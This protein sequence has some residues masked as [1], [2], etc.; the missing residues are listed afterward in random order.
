MAE[1]N[2]VQYTE[3]DVQSFQNAQEMVLEQESDDLEPSQVPITLSSQMKEPAVDPEVVAAEKILSPVGSGSGSIHDLFRRSSDVDSVSQIENETNKQG[4]SVASFNA[5]DKQM[6]VHKMTTRA[7]S[8]YSSQSRDSVSQ[9]SKVLSIGGSLRSRSI[10]TASSVMSRVSTY[11]DSQI[12]DIYKARKLNQQKKIE[13]EKI[14]LQ[15]SISQEEAE[16]NERMRQEEEELRRKRQ[17]EK[18]SFQKRKERELNELKRRD[19]R[20]Q[21]ELD[22]DFTEAMAERGL[23]FDLPAI[24]DTNGSELLLGTCTNVSNSNEIQNVSPPEIRSNS[25]AATI[26]NIVQSTVPSQTMFTSAAR[27]PSYSLG[28]V[29][30]SVPA[31]GGDQGMSVYSSSPGFEIC[32]HTTSVLGANECMV[33]ASTASHNANNHNASNSIILPKQIDSAVNPVNMLANQIQPIRMSS[34]AACPTCTA[35]SSYFATST[36]GNNAPTSNCMTYSCTDFASNFSSNTG[37]IPLYNMSQAANGDINRLTMPIINEE[38]T[39]INIPQP[40]QVP[41]QLSPQVIYVPQQANLPP[42]EP[43]VFSGDPGEYHDFIDIFDTVIAAKVQNAKQRFVYLLQYTRGTAR[44]L[45]KGCQHKGS[46]CYDEALKLLA[47]TYGHKL[48]IEQACLNSIIEGPQL[49]TNDLEALTMFAA[50]LI[51]C[52]NTLKGIKNKGLSLMIIDKISWRMPSVWRPGWRTLVDD[53]LHV[54]EKD[55]TLAHLVSYVRKKTRELSN[56]S[57]PETNNVQKPREIANKPMKQHKSYFTTTVSAADKPIPKCFKC[58]GTHFLNQCQ[59]FRNMKHADRERFVRDLKLCFSCLQKGHWSRQCRRENPCRVPNCKRKHTTLLHPP[60]NVNADDQSEHHKPA[61]DASVSK[62]TNENREENKFSAFVNS[63]SEARVLLNVIPVKVRVKGQNDVVLTNAFFD[64]GST[65]SFMS[66]ALMQRLNATGQETNL[67]IRTISNVTEQK[68]SS[69]IND[70]ELSH[71]DESDFIA[72]GQLF[73]NKCIDID[74]SNIP[75][76]KDVDQFHEFKDVVIPRLNQKVGLL[77]GKDNFALHKPLEIV[78]GPDE[79]FAVRCPAGW[80]ISCPPKTKKVERSNSNF[81]VKSS[82]H[83]LCKMCT[84]VVDSIQNEKSEFS[85]NQE[86]F[87]ERVNKSIHLTTDGHYEIDL[88]FKNPNVILPKN[89]SHAEQRL[90]YLRRRFLKEPDFYNEYKSFV[91]DM[92]DNGYAEKVNNSGEC[93]GKTWYL[94]HHGV[95]HPEKKSLRVVFDCSAKFSGLCLND[96]LLQGPD[97]ANNLVGVLARFRKQSVAIQGDIRAMFHQVKVSEPHRDF[98]RFLWW[99]NGDV[100]QPVACFRMTSFLFG[101]ICSPSCANFALKRTAEDNKEDFSESTVT[102]VYDAFYVDDFLD[103]KPNAEE[104]ID[105]VKNVRNLVSKGGFEITKW[106]SNDRAV[107]LSIPEEHRAKDVKGLDLS[108]DDL[109]VEK[110]LGM[111]W[112]VEQDTLC[113]RVK[114]K[115]KPATKRG[116]LSTINSIFDPLGF[117]QP[118]LQP[119][120]VLIQDLC[121]KKFDWDDPIPP[122]LKKEWLKWLS[123]LPKLKN[124]NVPRCYT[125]KDF[126]KIIDIQLHHFSDASEK[127]YGA[128]S[129]IRITNTYGQVH[130][131]IISGKTRLVPL[132]GSTILRLELCA[133]TIS[134]KND[135]FLKKELKL[136]ISASYF[137]TDSTTVLRY[138]ANTDKVFKTFVANRVNLIKETSEIEQWRYVPSQLNPADVASRGLSVDAFLNCQYWKSGPDFLW[139]AAEE[140]PLQPDFMNNCSTDNLEVKKE[141][142]Q[143]FSNTASEKSVLD[144]II[145]KY[146]DWF[147]L[148][149]AFAWILRGK[150]MLFSKLNANELHSNLPKENRIQPLSVTELR[151]A[152]LEIIKY[153]Q[154]KYFCEEIRLLSNNQEISKSSTLISLRPFL[155]NDILRVGGRIKDAPISYDAKH[156]IVIPK[157]SLIASLMVDYIHRTTGHNGREYVL[158]EIRQNYWIVKGTSLVRKIINNCVL[159]RRKQRKPEYQEMSDLP[160]DRVTPDKPP[161]SYV[162]LDCFGPFFIRQGRS[163]VKRYGV[164]FTCLTTRAVHV[165]I[166][167]NLDMNSFIMALRRFVSRRGQVL[168]IRRDNG[169]NFV[170]AEHELRQAIKCWNQKQVHDYLLQKNIKWMFQTPSASHHGGVF[171]RQIRTVRKVLNSICRE[172]TL[173]DEALS[174]LMCECE[175][176]ING[177]P[178][179]TVSSDVNDL[180]PLSPN[181]LLLLKQEP[182]LPPGLFEQKDVYS[183]K[184]W[185]QVQYLADIFWQR[186]RKEYLP[187][188][189]QR[190][191]WNKPQRNMC[192]N[193]IV[194]IVDH[195][196]PRNTWLLGRVIKTFPGKEGIVRSVSVQTQYSVLQRP[197]TKLILLHA[198]N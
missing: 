80:M 178:I 28:D 102:A 136:P 138:L 62:N 52:E 160:V 164:L 20:T 173:S 152:E 72:L 134:A 124:F 97:L 35:S 56:L 170:A 88:P 19:Q 133:A 139:Q 180:T 36:T 81:F 108:V 49:R 54:K 77:I 31:I 163:D 182:V 109:P 40:S 79:Y 110:A 117:G 7:K 190:K 94:S 85:P 137:W 135:A 183:R 14:Q 120:K 53:T 115:D 105:H 43:P 65:C 95:R 104:A 121:R 167:Q 181:L 50:E 68:K 175:S 179:T 84:E 188:L 59:E 172:Q 83:P 26:E 41:I 11:S 5:E 197:V 42:T 159:C 147:R 22:A 61:G 23:P 58:S 119:M 71:F 30:H 34:Y 1:S 73:S 185:K 74:V 154:S 48:Q 132:N 75:T 66:E 98:L 39:Q 106:V 82:V 157:D 158:A 116:L 33:V 64:T 101:T 8:K 131:A 76:Q 193:D 195:N 3:E 141:S 155:K 112:D 10:R 148:K 13:L 128:V 146:S 176:I 29:S 187:L 177:R 191:K 111:I 99:R 9:K 21:L 144:R 113:F 118:V 143:C 96:V 89:K 192:A 156:P 12:Q 93:D 32:P 91:K 57:N 184:R 86:I 16:W 161:F 69:V 129:Y 126:G 151:N 44:A 171:E 67:N 46:A 2:P 90:E 92:I 168:E 17:L 24:S 140:W 169:S 150:N 189:Q 60:D 6:N 198:C 162:A 166:A 123:D 25:P 107:L 15:D 114:H 87:M 186:W 100:S 18:E 4:K 174:T 38:A 51:A 130:C 103:S 145:S 70:I 196:L 63:A 194:L 47:E 27:Q 45:V 55:L 37:T 78:H 149:K 127:S 125:P 142:I 153:E 165:E 122:E